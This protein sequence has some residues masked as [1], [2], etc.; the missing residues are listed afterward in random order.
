MKSSDKA[1]RMVLDCLRLA[2]SRISG[3][4][5]RIQTAD[6]RH[7]TDER[8]YCYELYHQLRECLTDRFSFTLMGE[9]GKAPPLLTRRV[10]PDFLLHVPGLSGEAGGNLVAIEVKPLGQ[11]S[12][13]K[14]RDD[15]DKLVEF[16]TRG[17]YALGI[18][19][20]YH[21]EYRQLP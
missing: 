8:T 5:I 2:G 20:I 15:I 21:H 17:R 6:A 16:T 18:L 4:Y 1:I 13:R 12:P 10:R 14:L 19:L 3:E 9:L 11:T 7:L